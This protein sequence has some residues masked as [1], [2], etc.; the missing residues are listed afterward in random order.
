[1]NSAYQPKCRQNELVVQ[2]LRNELLIYDLQTHKASCLNETSALVWSLGAGGERT[3][4]K[5]N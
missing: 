3:V 5:K 2:E 4:A 1:M